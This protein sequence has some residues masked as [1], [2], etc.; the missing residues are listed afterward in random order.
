M[1]DVLEVSHRPHDPYRP[2]VC[3]DETSKQ[4]VAETREFLPMLPASRIVR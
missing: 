2:F 3:L 4:F 1:E